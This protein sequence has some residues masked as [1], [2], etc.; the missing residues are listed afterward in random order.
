MTPNEART[1]IGSLG[2]EPHRFAE[3]FGY[4]PRSV[5]HWQRGD[6]PIPHGTGVLLRLLAEGTIGIADVEAAAAPGA[7]E[8]ATPN[9]QTMEPP[10]AGPVAPEMT[11]ATESVAEPAPEPVP[12]PKLP[13]DAAAPI[14]TVTDEQ[15]EPLPAPTG[16]IGFDQ[17]DG[18]RC[19]WPCWPHDAAPPISEMTFCGRAA[20]A[21]SAYCDA[22]A[23]QARRALEPAAASLPQK[24]AQQ[25]FGKHGRMWPSPRNLTREPATGVAGHRAR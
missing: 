24:P 12:A 3:L 9:P 10:A 2:I 11:S 17:I 7:N 23:A 18:T 6:R 1:I 20:T 19:R 8:A 21:D 15:R 22:H 5:R 16:P 13:I 14:E 4:S 25:R